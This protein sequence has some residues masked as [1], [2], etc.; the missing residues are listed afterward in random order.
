MP[1]TAFQH[2]SVDYILKP[3]T[4][5]TLAS[6]FNKYKQM[7]SVFMAPDYQSWPAIIKESTPI[8]YK[9]RFLARLVPVLFLY[10]QKM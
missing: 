4:A 2:Y 8:R 3:V 1:S 5:E 10:R 9:D 7:A 6:A